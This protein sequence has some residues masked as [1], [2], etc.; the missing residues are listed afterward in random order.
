MSQRVYERPY[1]RTHCDTGYS[2]LCIKHEKTRV[3]HSLEYLFL[4]VM[5]T[6]PL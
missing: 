1:S 5:K 4:N 2:V 6:R 3:Q